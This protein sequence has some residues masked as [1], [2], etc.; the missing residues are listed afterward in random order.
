MI[1]EAHILSISPKNKTPQDWAD[2]FNSILPQYQIDTKLR[3]CAFLSQTAHESAGF[4]VLSEN[5]NYSKE[6]LLKVFPKYFNASNVDKYA[7]K[8]EAIANKVYGGRMGNGT[9]ETGDGFRFKGRGII[10]L[11]GH[12][13]YSKYSFD[14]YQSD[15]I[16]LN[17]ELVAS[18]DDAIKSACWYWTKNKLNEIADTG[19]V[20]LLTKRINGGAH[21]L[22]DRNL[23][24]ETLMRYDYL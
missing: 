18:P 6:G 20:V 4:T 15:V 23:K 12:D 10:Q 2:K 17:P 5:L 24:Y 3:I 9:E 21:G 16:I 7:R 13:N 11:T 19:D 22:E 1:T 14:T 8:P